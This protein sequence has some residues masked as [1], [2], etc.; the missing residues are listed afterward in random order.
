MNWRVRHT[1]PRIHS[2]PSWPS[3]SCRSHVAQDST[4]FLLSTRKKNI[5]ATQMDLPEGVSD[6]PSN[7]NGPVC[8]PVNVVRTATIPSSEAIASTWYLKSGKPVCQFFITQR[9]C[10]GLYSPSAEMP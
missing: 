5:S 9:I 6:L 7:E 8:V 2:Q 10:S 3:R 4:T 1:L